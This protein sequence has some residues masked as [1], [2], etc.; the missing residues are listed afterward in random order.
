MKNLVKTW[1]NN[2]NHE[3]HGEFST[4]E[5]S[6]AV[7]HDIPGNKFLSPFSTEVEGCS[8]QSCAC[9]DFLVTAFFALS[10]Y[11]T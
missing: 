10:S 1:I 6:Y 11:Y 9:C 5:A 2:E 8:W 7:Q 4:L 3:I